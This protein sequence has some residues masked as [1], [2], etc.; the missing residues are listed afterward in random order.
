MTVNYKQ[1][2]E[3]VPKDPGVYL[4]KDAW[5]NIIYIGKAKNL[6]KRVQSYFRKA[7]HSIKTQLLVKNI[8]GRERS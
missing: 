6:R 7:D 2:I 1:L 3:P 8:T 4:F 5:E